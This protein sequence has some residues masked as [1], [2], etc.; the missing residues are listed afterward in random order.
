MK[1]KTY[2][3]DSGVDDEDEKKSLKA[4]LI[5]VLKIVLKNIENKIDIKK[6]KSLKRRS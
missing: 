3:R 4:F 2:I 5:V 6:D 1:S